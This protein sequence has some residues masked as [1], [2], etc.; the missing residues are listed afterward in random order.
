MITMDKLK[1]ILAT[2]RNDIINTAVFDRD[3]YLEIKDQFAKPF[4]LELHG[5]RRSGKNPSD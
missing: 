4:P 2:W 5:L 1:E 3:I